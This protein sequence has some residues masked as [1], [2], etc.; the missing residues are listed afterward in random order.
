MI[1]RSGL[2]M[3]VAFVELDAVDD[4]AAVARQLDVALLLDI[5]RTRLGELAG[6]AADLDHRLL[7]AE[8]QHNGHLQED[9]EEVA[10][11][12]GLVLGEAFGAIAA[13]EQK[14]P[15]FGDV[16]ERRGQP[17]GLTRKNQRRKLGQTCLG[18]LQCLCIRIIR[19]LLDRFVA[20]A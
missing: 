16:G 5:G 8:G 2:G 15:A 10:D 20:P 13:L 6:D 7:G 19:D 1:W 3:R 18:H 11:V 9:A 4:V 17:A 14:A 12:V